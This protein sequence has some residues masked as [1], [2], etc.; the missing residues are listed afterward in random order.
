MVHRAMSIG[1]AAG[2]AWVAAAN[3]AA[4]ARDG[5]PTG[6]AARH[7]DLHGGPTHADRHNR[8][9]PGRTAAA[10]EAR[11]LGAAV[12]QHCNGKADM[13]R[14]DHEWVV[15]CSN[16]KTYVVDEKAQHAGTPAAECSLAG[17]G[18]Q[19]ACFTE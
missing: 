17:I 12:G 9:R 4:W 13:A 14:N 18:P 1:L 19:P 8:F 7:A 3:A 6:A 11:R 2:L 10:A 15:L 5:V 16:G